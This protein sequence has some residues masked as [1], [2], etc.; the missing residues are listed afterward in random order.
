MQ[1]QA[2]VLTMLLFYQA[3]T[4]SVF[5]AFTELPTRM[6]GYQQAISRSKVIGSSQRT[7][8]REMPWGEGSITVRKNA[9]TQFLGVFVV[10]SGSST[11]FNLRAFNTQ[12]GRRVFLMQKQHCFV[13]GCDTTISVF[14]KQSKGW[15]DITTDMLPDFKPEMLVRAYQAT[16]GKMA[17]EG[18]EE[19]DYHLQIPEEG[20]TIEMWNRYDEKMLDLVWN[21]HRFLIKNR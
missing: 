3:P 6:L 1:L 14:E 15:K 12:E 7:E 16:T 8:K 21:G 9:S 13:P 4:P 5:Q 20:N 11:S 19:L 17:Q 10:E 2:S 18:S